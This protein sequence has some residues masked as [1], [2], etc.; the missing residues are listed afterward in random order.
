MSK[1]ELTAIGMDVDQL[2]FWDDIKEQFKEL[3]A[4]AEDKIIQQMEDEKRMPFD[5]NVIATAAPGKLL[6]RFLNDEEQA[7][8]DKRFQEALAKYSKKYSKTLEMLGDD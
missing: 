3:A 5:R 7:D 6:V 4:E 8:W 2:V 1:E